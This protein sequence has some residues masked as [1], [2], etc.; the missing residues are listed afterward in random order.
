MKTYKVSEDK[1]TVEITETIQP[2]KEIKFN[3]MTDEIVK[4]LLVEKDNI[5]KNC[6]KRISDIDATI[7]S[8]HSDGVDVTAIAEKNA[9][10]ALLPELPK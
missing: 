2:P 10:E 5:I 6:A 9:S 4:E 3:K 8:F 1:R 7:A